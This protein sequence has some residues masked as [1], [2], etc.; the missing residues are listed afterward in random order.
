MLLGQER[1][2][3][4]RIPHFLNHVNKIVR[5][6]KQWAGDDK[7][8]WLV[9]CKRKLPISDEETFMRIYWKK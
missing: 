2:F 7:E 8:G 4:T 6:E 5:E 9:A 1:Y 3:D